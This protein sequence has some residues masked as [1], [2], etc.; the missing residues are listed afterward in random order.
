MNNPS[1]VPFRDQQTADMAE[2]AK[3][4]KGVAKITVETNEKEIAAIH[5]QLDVLQ[6]D[7]FEYMRLP[8]LSHTYI[9]LNTKDRFGLLP[10]FIDLLV[11]LKKRL[12]S[13]GY[14]VQ[15]FEQLQSIIDF[16]EKIRKED[17][18]D[19]FPVEPQYNT[20][21]FLTQY[22]ITS[23]LYGLQPNHSEYKTLKKI[24]QYMIKGYNAAIISKRKAIENCQN[25]LRKK[26]YG[27]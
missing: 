20:S 7:D 2:Y 3:N 13:R 8:I 25:I 26:L 10:M 17:T 6:A 23:N 14:Q 11:S 16:A 18:L 1:P 4:L 27:E 15:L 12:A 19:D 24:R 5:Q 22:F 21:Q 9:I